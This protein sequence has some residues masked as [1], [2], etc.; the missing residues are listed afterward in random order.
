MALERRGLAAAGVSA[1]L[2][3]VACRGAAWA[4]FVGAEAAAGADPADVPV[5]QIL[6]V[7]VLRS[8]V[9]SMCVAEMFLAAKKMLS[10]SKAEKLLEIIAAD[11]A[12]RGVDA[13]AG[14]ASEKK[15]ADA[16][17]TKSRN[18]SK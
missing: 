11:A 7:V 6:Q 14:A 17:A 18:I 15:F 12:E 9:T 13:T 1:A 3:A 5:S 2:A 4:S 16:I 8:L 10:S